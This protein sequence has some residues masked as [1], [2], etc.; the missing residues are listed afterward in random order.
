MKR[1]IFGISTAGSPL[2]RRKAQHLVHTA[3]L[4]KRTKLLT[5]AENY[6]YFSAVT[7]GNCLFVFQRFKMRSVLRD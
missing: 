1:T 3:Y 2:H 6:G 5:N 4:V 7:F